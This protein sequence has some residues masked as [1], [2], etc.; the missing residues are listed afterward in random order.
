[1]EY[2]LRIVEGFMRKGTK[3]AETRGHV[4]PFK[5]DGE[6]F[7]QRG[8]KAYQKRDL[9]KAK[10]L[11]ERALVFEPNEA[12]YICQLAATLA[13]LD[14][15]DESNKWL[16]FLVTEIDPEMSECYF[17]MANNYA[18]LGKFKEAEAEALRYME[19]DP[20]GEFQEDTQELLD[21]IAIENDGDSSEEAHAG[22][23]KLIAQHERARYYIESGQFDE[24]KQLLIKLIDDYPDFWA[25]YNNL[26]LTYYYLKKYNKAF[27][28]LEQVLS[29]NP[30]NLHALCNLALFYDHLGKYEKRNKII[31]SLKV[32]YPISPD[33]RFK[34]GTTLG[35]LE[36]NEDAF[37]WLNS[38]KKYGHEWDYTFF[39]WY[40]VAAFMTGRTDTAMQSWKKVAEL[41]PEGKIAPY[42][43]EKIENGSLKKSGVDYHYRI[44]V[45]RLKRNHRKNFFQR[46]QKLRGVLHRNKLAHLFILEKMNSDEAH[47]TLKEFCL[48]KNES[49][50]LK[51]IAAHIVLT[52]SDEAAVTIRDGKNEL[53]YTEPLPPISKGLE[54]L[55]NLCEANVD[56]EGLVD[57][58]MISIWHELVET[59]RE[60]P[61]MLQ[62]LFGWAAAIDYT[63]R[64][65]RSL[66]ATQ[67]DLAQKYNLS[68]ATVGKY[69]KKLQHILEEKGSY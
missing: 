4:I 12:T 47:E 48:Q 52:L 53:H 59:A 37:K 49:I 14:D 43:L 46:L 35:V 44:P 21:I 6:Y 24:A 5:Q 69:V 17:F 29:K 64:Q 31:E 66:K 19:F 54:L 63:W 58:D 9:Y 57:D 68:A 50:V 2:I 16:Q 18:H 55:K 42:Y 27:E 28:V 25:A 1:M 15:F 23:D 39:H 20:N 30:G 33:H 26:A 61:E 22:E 13:E 10:R 36:E 38:I 3:A 34:L 45:K 8:I 60:Q 62:N 40:A 65:K 56:G 11:F 67:K 7:Y 32:I 41:D 51:E